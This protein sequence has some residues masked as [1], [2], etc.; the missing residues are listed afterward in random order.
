MRALCVAAA[1]T[2]RAGEP[3]Y[4][5]AGGASELIYPWG[6]TPVPDD[7]QDGTAAYASYGC[8]A[9]N[10]ACAFADILPAGS[11]PSGVGRYGQL[12]LAGSMWEWALDWYASPYPTSPCNNCANLTTAKHRVVRGG[13]WSGV[14]T[15]LTAANRNGNIP[16]GHYAYVGFRCS[17][18]R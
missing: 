14:A 12:D 3:E 6:N 10:G 13:S 18:A 15:D 8:L 9:D 1:P 16:T 4:A 5:A 17:R 7:T 11:K 2:K